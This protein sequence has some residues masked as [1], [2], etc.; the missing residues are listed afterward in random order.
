[1]NQILMMQNKK[2]SKKK[3]KRKTSSGPVKIAAIVRFF[4]IIIMAFGLVLSGSGTYS[5]I[6]E[7]KEAENNPI[8]QVSTQREGNIVSLTVQSNIGIR[9][10]SYSWNDASSIVNEGLNRKEITLSI[11]IPTGSNKLNISVVDSTGKL[12][13]YVKNFE[14]SSSQDVTDPVIKFEVI[15]SGIKITATDDTAL[16]Y[17][18]YQ[19]GDG[20]EVT[21]NADESNQYV[22]ETILPVSQGQA[23]LTVEAFDKAGNVST[24]EQEVKGANKAKISVEPDPTDPSYI[25][26]KVEDDEGLRMVTYY[27]NEQDYSTDPNSSL[28]TKTFEWRQK[29]EPGESKVTVHAYN[30]NEQ[31]TEFVGIYNY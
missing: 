19:Y 10:I 6:Q 5:M 23:T 9:T 22:I 14:L 24:K 1:M 8:P 29:V 12:T 31:T 4:A 25:I 15:N 30:I 20:E 16:D 2:E 26:I 27:I 7:K 3:E 28:G 21:I 13:K 11:M 18:T 17:I